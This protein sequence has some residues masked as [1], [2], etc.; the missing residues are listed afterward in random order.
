[1]IHQSPDCSHINFN[2][3]TCYGFP[4]AS[5]NPV[6]ALLKDQK[7]VCVFLNAPV[8]NKVLIVHSY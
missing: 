8:I 5:G 1:M 6:R 4:K 3:L 2:E 7:P